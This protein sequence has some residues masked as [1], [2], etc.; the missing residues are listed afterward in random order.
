MREGATGREGVAHGVGEGAPL[1]RHVGVGHSGAR[2]LTE[3]PRAGQATAPLNTS[4]LTTPSL[5]AGTL[6]QRAHVPVL[7]ASFAGLPRAKHTRKGSGAER[8]CDLR[9]DANVS[10]KQSR[11]KWRSECRPLVTVASARTRGL[12]ASVF[13]NHYVTY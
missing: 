1:L 6:A 4:A 2:Q 10:T 3:R 11:T 8:S 5:N 12:R 13:V 7:E 9:R